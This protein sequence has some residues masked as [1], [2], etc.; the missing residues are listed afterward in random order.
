MKYKCPNCFNTDKQDCI[1]I[2][3]TEN[4]Y[5]Y[6]MECLNCNEEYSYFEKKEL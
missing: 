5:K 3:E 6:C 1:V 2:K 4:S